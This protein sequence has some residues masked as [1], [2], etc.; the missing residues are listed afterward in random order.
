MRPRLSVFF[1]YF[2]VYPSRVEIGRR[3]YY[4]HPVA[5]SVTMLD[6]YYPILVF[7]ENI[8][9]ARKIFANPVTP[10]TVPSYASP[11]LSLI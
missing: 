2:E 4:L 1:I 8:P 7:L 10:L 11:T 6:T 5:K 3:N 9:V